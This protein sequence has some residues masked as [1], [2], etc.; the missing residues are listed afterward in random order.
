[1][2]LPCAWAPLSLA[3]THSLS[4]SVRVPARRRRVSTSCRACCRLRAAHRQLRPSPQPRPPLSSLF[5]PPRHPT[6][7]ARRTHADTPCG[8]PPKNIQADRCNDPAQVN[9]HT[10]TRSCR[11]TKSDCVLC[12]QR[13][14][15]SGRGVTL[16][17]A[18]THSLTH[19]HTY[20]HTQAH[21]YTYT[22]TFI[23]IHTH[24]H[25]V[26]FRPGPWAVQRYR[27]RSMEDVRANATKS[28]VG[29]HSDPPT[30]PDTSTTSA[31]SLY[32]YA[33]PCSYNYTH[34]HTR[35]KYRHTDTQTDRQTNLLF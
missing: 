1:M 5:I 3:H 25:S 14:V 22:P 11:H 6:H 15:K 8:P 32:V 34:A 31:R 16:A 33:P 18:P 4:H 24:T 21:T 13:S 19:S 35:F 17:L 28:S 9:T 20:A 27:T 30:P 12:A 26:P 29:V 2:R 10:H 23:N 7:L